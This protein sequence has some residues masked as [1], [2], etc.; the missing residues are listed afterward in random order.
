MAV[1]AR[2]DEADLAA[3]PPDRFVARGVGVSASISSVTSWW[4]RRA[5]ALGERRSPADEVALVPGDP[6]VHAGHARRV[7]LGELRRPDPEALFE[8]QRE[9]GVVAVFPDAEVAAG[10]EQ[11]APQRPMFERAAVDLVAE[12]AH[13]RDA[14]DA[15]ADKPDVDDAAAMNGMAALETS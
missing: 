7:G 8:P 14:R 5:V 2:G 6:A 1:A 4:R 12:F 9:Q 10:G 11:R 15:R 13:D 3:V